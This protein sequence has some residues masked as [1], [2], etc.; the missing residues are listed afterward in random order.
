MKT[1]AMNHWNMTYTRRT[2][3]ASRNLNSGS[4]SRVLMLI[5]A[6]TLPVAVIT[7]LTVWANNTGAQGF[8]SAAYWTTGFI[9]LAV[10]VD[11]ADGHRLPLAA[12]GLTVMVLAWMSSR[13][14]PEFAVVAGF[15]V[16]AWLAAP[17]ISRLAWPRAKRDGNPES[18]VPGF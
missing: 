4:A 18:P 12:S 7:I 16:A 15:M 11:A 10:M 14:A 1:D 8:V 2:P 17:I 9:F 3:R 13:I 6:A 5:L